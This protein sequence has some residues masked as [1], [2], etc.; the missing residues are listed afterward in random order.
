MQYLTI[1]LA[2]IA[3]LI[4]PALAILFRAAIR[5]KGIEDKL[6]EAVRDLKSIVDDKNKV[7]SEIVAQMREDRSATDRRL[8][9][10]E[11]NI[12][13]LRQPKD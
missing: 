10:L 4:T 1:M 2:V 9:W 6:D 5:W 11:E 7:H 3:V 12:W 13:K 8:R